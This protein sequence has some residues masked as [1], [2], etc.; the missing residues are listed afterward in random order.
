MYAR[1]DQKV[2]VKATT[3]LVGPILSALRPV[4]AITEGNAFSYA[5]QCP[6]K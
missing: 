2:V 5:E 4:D 3:T 1:R 6:L